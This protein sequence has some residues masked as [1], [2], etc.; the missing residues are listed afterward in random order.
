MSKTRPGAVGVG[1]GK[2][3]G[4]CPGSGASQDEEAEG[5][6]GSRKKRGNSIGRNAGWGGME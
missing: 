4:A 6:K 2:A 1:N 5:E 3:S